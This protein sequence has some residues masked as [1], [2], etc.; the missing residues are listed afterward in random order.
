[1]GET[2]GIGTHY[3]QPDL[4]SM[5]VNGGKIVLYVCPVEYDKRAHHATPFAHPEEVMN[6]IVKQHFPSYLPTS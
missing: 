4:D 2:G 3:R 5:K 1:M 6:R